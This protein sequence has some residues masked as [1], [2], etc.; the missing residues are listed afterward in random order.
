MPDL[1]QLGFRDWIRNLIAAFI[2]GG[3][4]AVVSGITVSTMDPSDY[5]VGTHKF[6]TLVMTMFIVNGIIGMMAY[7]KQKPLPDITTTVRKAEETYLAGH[8]EPAKVVKTVTET[9]T[10]VTSKDK[11]QDN[12]AV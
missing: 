5:A 11:D 8:E 9:T 7:L 2:T 4:S 10:A 12:G 6:Y 3:A 1:S